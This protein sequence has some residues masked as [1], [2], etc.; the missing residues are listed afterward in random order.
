[1]REAINMSPLNAPTLTNYLPVFFLC[2]GLKAGPQLFNYT[3]RVYTHT[4][5]VTSGSKETV[6]NNEM[7]RTP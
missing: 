7:D 4:H 2:V 1:M 6:L 5:L 3:A